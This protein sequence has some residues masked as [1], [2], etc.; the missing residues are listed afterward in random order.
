[1][2][3]LNLRK[4]FRLINGGKYFGVAVNLAIVSRLQQTCLQIL[5]LAKESKL[6]HFNRRETGRKIKKSNLTRMYIRP[7]YTHKTGTRT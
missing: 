1:M 5:Y 2:S 4:L 6:K 7:A 3:I